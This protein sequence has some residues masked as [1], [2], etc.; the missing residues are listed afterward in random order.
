MS[1]RAFFSTDSTPPSPLTSLM[2]PENEFT[3]LQEIIKAPLGSDLY[4][5]R[6]DAPRQAFPGRTSPKQ[7]AQ[8]TRA[9]LVDRGVLEIVRGGNAQT[10]TIIRLLANPDGIRMSN[11]GR[12]RKVKRAKPPH[13]G[14]LTKDCEQSVPASA[15]H[16]H[17][18]NPESIDDFYRVLRQVQ[19]HFP[20]SF[21]QFTSTFRL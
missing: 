5:I 4:E 13:D 3:L 9:R 11:A 19:A 17:A 1:N 21:E 15:A 16:D 18:S 12:G 14:Y 10:R 20:N 7:L 8:S 2:L 6:K